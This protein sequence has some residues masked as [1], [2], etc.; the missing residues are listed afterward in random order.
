MINFDVFRSDNPLLSD[1][2]RT[3]GRINTQTFANAAAYCLQYLCN[4]LGADQTV[5]PVLNSRLRLMRRAC[6]RRW[7]RRQVVNKIRGWRETS[8]MWSV[9][10]WDE[11]YSI[12]LRPKR[13]RPLYAYQRLAVWKRPECNSR[14]VENML[15]SERY[16]LGLY[17]LPILLSRAG[18]SDTLIDLC[19]TKIFASKMQEFPRASKRARAAMKLY[20]GRAGYR[21]KQ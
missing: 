12:S 16:W 19:Q 18:H 4:H 7:H 20:L 3:P 1:Y 15:R 2:L 21:L 10:F 5:I 14:E 8:W 11:K 17:Y 6:P 13:Y 9:Y